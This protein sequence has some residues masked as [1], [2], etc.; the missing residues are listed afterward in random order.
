[1][2]REPDAAPR[3]LTAA[4]EAGVTPNARMY[5]TLINMCVRGN[6]IE[7]AQ[8]LCDDMERDGHRGSDGL[9]SKVAGRQQQRN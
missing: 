3:M 4:R 6:N 8:E 1:M 2:S 9:R 5:A 7:R